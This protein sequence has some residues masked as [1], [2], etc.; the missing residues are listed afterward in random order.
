MN[1]N[2]IDRMLRED[3]R[4]TPSAGFAGRVMVT[5]RHEAREREGLPFPWVRFLPGLGACVVFT[6]VG[7]VWALVTGGPPPVVLGAVAEALE[8]FIPAETAI[9]VSMTLLGSYLL[10]M[11]SLRLAGHRR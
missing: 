4:I 7:I 2:E 1:P 9:W 10:T 6:G 8:R 3:P 5:V 11:G